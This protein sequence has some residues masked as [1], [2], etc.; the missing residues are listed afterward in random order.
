MD[1][2]NDMYRAN[3]MC[4]STGMYSDICNC[5]CCQYSYDCSGSN[6]SWDED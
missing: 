6:T 3:E 5:D 2:D 4:W 1:F